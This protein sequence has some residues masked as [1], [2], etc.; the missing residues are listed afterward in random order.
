[1]WYVISGLVAVVVAMLGFAATR[2]DHFRI[3]RS[4][5]VNAPAERIHPLIADFRNW[6]AWSPWEDR[7]PNLERSYAGNPSGRGATY[8]WR[9]NSQAGEGR[10]EILADEPQRIA[11]RL[12]FIKPFA[13]QNTAEFVL[14]PEA[15]GTRI[16]WAM[17]GPQPFIARLMGLV[18]SMDRMVGGDFETGL[19]RMKAAAEA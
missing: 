1:M 3:E 12:D 7:D 17:F 9:G 13:A 5:I 16:T 2:A 6:R 18:F 4:I 8:A 10:M 11:I 15:G 14:T 19:G